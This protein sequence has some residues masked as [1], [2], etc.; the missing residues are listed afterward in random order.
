MAPARRYPVEP[1][2]HRLGITLGEPGRPDDDTL[3]GH[4]ALAAR[5]QISVAT[6]RRIADAGLTEVQADRAAIRLGLHPA[7]LWPTWWTN[8]LHVDEDDPDW[9]ADDPPLEE[10]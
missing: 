6:A 7:N 3:H 1:L 4:Q 9:F 10:V 2:A 8:D 5:L